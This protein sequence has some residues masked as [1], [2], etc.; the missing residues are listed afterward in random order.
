MN[1]HLPVVLGESV[2]PKY[3]SWSNQVRVDSRPP[4]PESMHQNS[5]VTINLKKQNNENSCAH[6][7]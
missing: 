4:S 5:L 7:N 3:Y 6:Y 1:T 2:G